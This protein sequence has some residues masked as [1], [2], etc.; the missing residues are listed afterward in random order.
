MYRQ[1]KGPSKFEK[2][3]VLTHNFYFFKKLRDILKNATKD[4]KD[5]LHIYKI[6]KHKET[7]TITAA[8]NEFIAYQSEYLSKIAELKKWYKEPNLEENISIGVAIRKVFEIFLSYQAPL[9]TSTFQKFESVFNDEETLKY[10][11]LEG[12]ANASCHTDEIDDLDALEPYKLSV[13][14]DEIK[15]LFNFIREVDERHAD[16][17]E[18]PVISD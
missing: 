6:E 16:A 11:Y 15:Q 4:S 1:F 9:K 5:N 12:I 18:L 13:G 7:S 2:L 3:F 8:T 10:R 17:L 14:K